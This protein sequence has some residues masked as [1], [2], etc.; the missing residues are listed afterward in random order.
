M[1]IP[2]NGYEQAAISLAPI[3][4]DITLDEFCQS[5]LEGYEYF[6]GA[7]IPI[8]PTT[9]E[10]GEISMNIGVFLGLHVRENQLGRLYMAGTDF[11]LCD[12]LVKP[13]AAFVSTARLPGNRREVFSVAPDLAVEVVAPLDAFQR[14]IE[15]AFAYLEAGTQIVWVVEPRSKTVTVYR[16][17]TNIKVLTREDTLTGEDVVEG[18]S[19]QVA[20]LFE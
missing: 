12:R 8:A 20:Q 19:C 17:E 7:L 13:D 11:K 2:K 3:E 16:S 15:K 9:M 5:D 14:M 18:F 10:H 1:D 6:N 4:T